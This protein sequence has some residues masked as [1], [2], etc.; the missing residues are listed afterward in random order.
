MTHGVVESYSRDIAVHAG[1]LGLRPFRSIRAPDTNEAPHS[2]LT[3]DF[4]AE[5]KAH[6]TIR[7]VQTLLINFS[8][9]FPHIISKNG[10][11]FLVS[12]SLLPCSKERFTTARSDMA[13]EAIHESL[14]R[15]IN[16]DALPAEV[17]IE[18]G[19]CVN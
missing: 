5:I 18:L 7:K 6:H 3:F 2:S 16:N 9:G 15:L 14:V 12:A 4:R 1:Q 10:P 8:V 17:I 19:L 11:A 13:L